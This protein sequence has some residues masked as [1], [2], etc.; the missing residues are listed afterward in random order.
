MSHPVENYALISDCHSSALI[1]RD[2]S[3]D[4]LAFPCFDSAPF[5]AS[6]LGSEEN[7]R[8]IISPK[9]YFVSC[10][11]YIKDTMVLETVFEASEGS[12]KLTDCMVMEEKCP[13]LVRM[14]EGLTGHVE[15]T[16]EIVL[17][18]DYGS[19]VPWVRTNEDKSRIHAV[20]GPEA[21]SLYSDAPLVGKNF[22]TNSQF[23]VKAG[24]RKYF[25]LMWHP[26]HLPQP[27][28]PA[29]LEKCIQKT[30][31]TWKTWADKCQYKGF[32]EK[33][34]KRSLIT[35]KALTYE[36]TG[37][38]VASPTTS[39]PED[40]GGTRNW[41]Y[42]HGWLRDSSFALFALIKGG[43]F[44]E[45]ARWNEWLL[46]A[47]AGT[48]SQLNIMY[49]I[50]AERRL[51]E[52]ELPWLKGY[53]N[54][55]P[56]RIGNDAYKQFQLDVFGELLRTAYLGRE[57]GILIDDNGWRIERHMVEYVCDHWQDPDEGIWEVRGGRRQFTHSKLMAWVALNC[58]I[59]SVERYGLQADISKWRRVRYQIHHA[60]CEKG[61]D[62]KLNSFVQ[63]FGS[64]ELDASLLMM[65]HVGFLP[66]TDP[67]I[68]GTV[69]A[70]RKYL[71]RDGH[72]LRY[73]N[74]TGVDGLP[75]TEGSFIA[76]SFWM[77]D[78]LR[79]MGRH[80]EALEMYHHI[81]SIKNDVGLYAEEYSIQHGRMV[82][83]F[84]QAFSHIAEAVT[85]M[86]LEG[87]IY[88]QSGNNY[89]KYTPQPDRGI[90][91]EMGV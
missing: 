71:M 2:G 20:A 73:L 44:E 79:M 91:G 88:A 3:I 63:I 72:V 78:A 28:L 90:S 58:A 57:N 1:D 15:I 26:S 46:R 29:S 23:S 56:V 36:P 13:T 54:S 31:D 7:G 43:Y 48:P 51:T 80:E 61:F 5:F 4:W 89:W 6:L 8:W 32:D 33:S 35:L 70:I 59:G 65:P 14:V 55:R 75:G 40:I 83:N 24:E 66:A 69:E 47:V 10:R 27:G 45:A 42:R 87:G 85:A 9:G 81:Q 64:Q 19:I 21:V 22:R 52:I 39:L 34:V 76:C 53:E 86:G 84:P 82:G 37:A 49:G 41:D 38:I 68:A 67:R 17:R 25:T 16:M 77:V 62:S 18:F 50:R 30:V 74:S 11:D 12:C 60:I